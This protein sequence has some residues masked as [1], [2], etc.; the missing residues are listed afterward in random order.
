MPTLA[1][2]GSGVAEKAA[3]A[4][5]MLSRA[6]WGFQKEREW[7]LF[8]TNERLGA[9]RQTALGNYRPDIGSL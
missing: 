2:L 6:V 1:G 7:R 5:D 3:A 9:P 4:G 8:E